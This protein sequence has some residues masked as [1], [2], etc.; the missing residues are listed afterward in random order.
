MSLIYASFGIE[1]RT[2][3]L[4]ES[5]SFPFS[6]GKSRSVQEYMKITCAGHFFVLKTNDGIIADYHCIGNDT[7][8][9]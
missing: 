8:I 9:L 2:W 7:F 4:L 1:N 6:F 5:G 3:F